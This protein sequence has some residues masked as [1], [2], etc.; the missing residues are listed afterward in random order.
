MPSSSHGKRNRRPTRRL[1]NSIYH[2]EALE[3]RML[4]ANTFTV[5][6]LNDSGNG[7]LRAAILSADADLSPAIINFAGGLSGTINLASALPDI[8]VGMTI[9]GP[10][11]SLLTI[12][13]HGHGS[14]LSFSHISASIN[15][16]TITGGN[17]AVG[18]G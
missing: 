12:N 14:V 9:N 16:L 17:S 5:S 4:L 2:A 1:V 8:Q 7:S 18:G 11:A 6:N 10:G 3:R 15:N 13:G